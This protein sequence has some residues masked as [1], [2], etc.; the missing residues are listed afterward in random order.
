M[1]RIAFCATHARDEPACRMSG[2]EGSRGC[3]SFVGDR[4]AERGRHRRH[5]GL[6]DLE[7]LC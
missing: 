3:A 4:D 1:Q 2:L 6:L 7:F 5:A